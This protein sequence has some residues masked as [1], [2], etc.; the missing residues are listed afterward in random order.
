[1]ND[2]KFIIVQDQYVANKL[3][4]HGFSLVSNIGCTYTFMNI[5][6]K[7]FSFEEIDVKKLVYTNTLTF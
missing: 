4:A 5:V 7:Q 6:P 2:A 1:M 3:I